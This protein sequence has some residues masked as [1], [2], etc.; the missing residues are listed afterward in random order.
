MKQIELDIKINEYPSY[1]KFE[2][3]QRFYE[4][5]EYCIKELKKL[6][7]IVKILEQI[8]QQQK[9]LVIIAEDFEGDTLPGMIINA[10]R[11]ALKVVAVKAPG[12]GDNRKEMLE[13]IAILTNGVVLSE[14]KGYKIDTA[15]LE[16]LNQNFF[17]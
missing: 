16:L 8:S 14:E 4:E 12:F 3:F 1:N 10:L 7:E 6:K 17:P 2:N 13:D 11:G 15:K 9:N 5:L